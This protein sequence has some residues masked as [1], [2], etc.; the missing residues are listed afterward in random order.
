MAGTEAAAAHVLEQM[1]HAQRQVLT[2]DTH[3][4]HGQA[5]WAFS[6]SWA[7]LAELV[8]HAETL[9][10]ELV[11]AARDMDTAEQLRRLGAGLGGAG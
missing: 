7:E 3:G 4:W 10:Q 11:A 8:G 2:A 9:A 1:Q 5:Q 6:L